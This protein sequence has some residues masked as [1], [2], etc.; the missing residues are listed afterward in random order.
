MPIVR[1]CGVCRRYGAP[2]PRHSTNERGYGGDHQAIRRELARTLPAPCAYGCGTTVTRESFVA[3]HVVDGDPRAG[4]VA[5]C[6]SCNERAKAGLRP[7]RLAAVVG[8]W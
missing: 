1:W 7:M 5:G 8:A 6:R 3:C 2:H 4:Y